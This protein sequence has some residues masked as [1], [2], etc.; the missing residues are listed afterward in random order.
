VL[1]GLIGQPENKAAVKERRKAYEKAHWKE[2]ERRRKEKWLAE[3]RAAPLKPNEYRCKSQEEFDAIL[4]SFRPWLRFPHDKRAQYRLNYMFVAQFNL[5]ERIRN[6]ITKTRG[7]S[8][9]LEEFLGCTKAELTQHIER[10]FT[11]GMSWSAFIDGRIE[12]DHIIPMSHFDL[13]NPLELKAAWALCNLKPRW[14][15]DNIAKGTKA[16]RLCSKL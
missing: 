5:C 2:R 13:S 15:K 4:Y 10:Q 1:D 6:E 9:K 3:W 14:R 11:R 16:G 12:V 7:K 8:A